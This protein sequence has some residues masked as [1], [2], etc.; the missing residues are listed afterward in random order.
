MALRLG[1]RL[2][3]KRPD[4]PPP[5]D[6]HRRFRQRRRAGLACYTIALGVAE[7][8]FLVTTG[9]LLEGEVTDRDAVGRRDRVA[10]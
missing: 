6:R 4:S 1:R 8:D 9:W 7:L 5:R 10:G 2:M 3:L